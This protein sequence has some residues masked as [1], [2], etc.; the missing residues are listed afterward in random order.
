MTTTN[1]PT[2]TTISTAT[3]ADLKRVSHALA[4]AFHDD[5]I[6][7]WCIPDPARRT[8]I[9]PRF[10]ELAAR[11]VLPHGSSTLAA[12][13]D[14]AAL[15]VPVGQPAIGEDDADEF[16]NAIAELLGDDIDRT[17]AIM[18]L[19][20]EHHPTEPHQFL[21]FIGVRSGAQGHGLGS[22]LLAATL[23]V[24]DDTETAAYLDATSP[25]NRRLY[26]RHGFT[27]AAERSTLGS[28]PIWAMWRAP[29]PR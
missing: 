5:P 24:C 16:M 29:R 13:G 10:F 4:D 17:T 22:Q 1:T 19:L 14:A 9:L 21:W 20:D 11:P 28:P 26:E 18:A 23:A 27:V 12:D 25:N 6:F 7:T 8:Q 2:N 3:L 15:W